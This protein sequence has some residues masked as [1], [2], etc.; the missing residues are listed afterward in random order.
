MNVSSSFLV[1]A[2]NRSKRR[3]TLLDFHAGLSGTYRRYL[4]KHSLLGIGSAAILLLDTMAASAA[5]GV[6]SIFWWALLGIIFFVPYGLISAEMG[7]GV[8]IALGEL[9]ILYSE[10]ERRKTPKLLP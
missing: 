5:I 7:T 1:S 9:A 6:S 2:R 8:S 4:K 3:Y 10:H